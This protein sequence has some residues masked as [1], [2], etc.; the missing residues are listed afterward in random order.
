MGNDTS[1]LPAFQNLP[2]LAFCVKDP[3][4]TLQNIVANYEQF[5]FLKTGQ[6]ITLAE[7]DPRRL[8]IENFAYVIAQQRS[9]FDFG[10]KQN[11][12]P[13][14]AYPYLDAKG[15]QW[16]PNK[17]PRQLPSPALCTLAFTL[18]VPATIDILVPQG[19]QVG[20]GN[21]I[22]FST[23][24]DAIIP[25]GSLNINIS[26]A[27][28][29]TGAVGNNYLPG[30]VNALTNW[31]IP[32][33]ITVVNI[34][35][36]TGGADGE[37]DDQFRFRQYLIPDSYGS[38]GSIGQ[39]LEAVYGVSP[40]IIDVSIIGPKVRTVPAINYNGG[41]PFPLGC[42]S[43]YI[44]EAG[45]SMPNAA[46]LSQV[47]T[48]VS[49]A[50]TRPTTDFDFVLS[51]SGINYTVSVTCG[52]D[53]DQ[54]PQQVTIEQNITNAVGTYNLWQQSKI[55]RALNPSYLSQLCMEAGAARC[56]VTSPSFQILQPY[57]VPTLASGS[58]A[59]TIAFVVPEQDYMY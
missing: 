55:G 30:Q 2:P 7:A 40:A 8:M 33:V 48:A 37:T 20:A 25:A 16:G 23:T 51:P 14:S 6:N 15:T 52:L 57:Q 11:L 28:T 17:G 3:V 19:T 31:N 35:T 49:D 45:P 32:Q 1:T 39:Y 54:I 29:V 44:L 10:C 36:S 58:G 13:F 50:W 24:Q 42:V 47:K 27:C 9:I 59:V 46:T 53:V 4:L 56:T 34:D 5:Y 12:L 18:A 21:G 26:A 38:S 43:M 22:I 41:P